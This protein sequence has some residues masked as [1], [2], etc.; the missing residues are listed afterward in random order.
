MDRNVYENFLKR[1][2]LYISENEKEN[3]P[4]LNSLIKIRVEEKGQLKHFLLTLSQ[5]AKNI[6]IFYHLIAITRTLIVKFI[7]EN[8]DSYINLLDNVFKKDKIP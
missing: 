8:A 7:R 4:D 3:L 1:F 6:F 5:K 2:G